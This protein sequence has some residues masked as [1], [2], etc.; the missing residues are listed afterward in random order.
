MDTS[1]TYIKMC[2]KAEEI[3]ND[4]NKDNWKE[5]DYC[6][7]ELMKKIVV[8]S[9]YE[10]DAGYY[11]HGLGWDNKLIGQT[12]GCEGQGKHIWLPRQDQLQEMLSQHS[13]WSKTLAFEFFLRKEGSYDIKSYAFQF[14]SMEQLWLAFVMEEKYN[15]VWNGENWIKE[16]E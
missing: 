8:I 15:K 14:T 13:L 16:I 9:G 3:Q 11:G 5:W 2:E 1:E 6:Y 7:C 4:Y 12:E 10:V